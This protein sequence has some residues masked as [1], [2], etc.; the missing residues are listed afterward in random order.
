[1]ALAR[2]TDS[3]LPAVPR[4]P[5][6]FRRLRP[7]KAASRRRGKTTQLINL[8]RWIGKDVL[9]IAVHLNAL[10]RTRDQGSA[11]FADQSV[12]AAGGDVAG[13][14]S[15]LVSRVSLN[16][17]L[18]QGPWWTREWR[19]VVLFHGSNIRQRRSKEKL[20]RR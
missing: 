16:L 18:Q 1:M 4:K 12:P 3:D 6:E 15:G 10:V 20:T 13:V 19:G 8:P 17:V 5:T 9:M 7:R 11:L 2:T 14:V